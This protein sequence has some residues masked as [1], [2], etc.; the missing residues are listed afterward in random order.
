MIC[1]LLAAFTS[2]P[3]DVVSRVCVCVTRR[4]RAGCPELVVATLLWFVAEAPRLVCGA[5]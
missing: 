5:L 1:L 4:A 3:S 2:T